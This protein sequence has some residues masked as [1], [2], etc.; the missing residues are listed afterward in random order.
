MAAARVTAAAGMPESHAEE[1]IGR[2]RR[3]MHS[4]CVMHIEFKAA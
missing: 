3:S 1:A 2:S 4:V